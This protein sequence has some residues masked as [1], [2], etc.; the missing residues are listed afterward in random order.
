MKVV[1]ITQWF[2]PEP[3]YLWEE[4]ATEL[5]NFGHEVTV[6]TAF[7][8]YPYGKIYDGYKQRTF[9]ESFQ[10]GYRLIRL[11]VYPDRSTS[12][13]KRGLSYISLFLCLFWWLG[14]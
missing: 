5:A 14:Y 11:P 12:I 1:L 6:V 7:P 13:I 8:N 3:A 9:E 2:P 4:L 10:N